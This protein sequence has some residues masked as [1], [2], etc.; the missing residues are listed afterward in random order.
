MQV[1]SF[2]CQQIHPIGRRPSKCTFPLL[3]TAA[4]LSKSTNHG[5]LLHCLAVKIGFM[6]HAPI[7]NSLMHMYASFDAFNYAVHVFDEMPNRDIVSYN[8]FLGEYVKGGDL[9]K[10]ES[11]FSSMPVI[12]VISWS[13]L[14]K[15]YVRN[16]QFEKGLGLCYQMLIL[17]L[18]PDEYVIVTLLSVITHFKLVPHGKM[19]HGFVIKRWLKITERVRTA[20]INFYCKCGHANSAIF[21]FRQTMTKNVSLWNTLISGIA[22]L[23]LEKEALQ[24]FTRMQMNGVRPN[25]DTFVCLLLT[26]GH[27]GLVEEGLEYFDIMSS[28]YGMKPTL[29]HYW[30]LVNLFVRAGQSDEALKIVQ[31]LPWDNQSSIWDA[32]IHLSK[33]SN[34]ISIGEYLGRKM[35]ELEPDNPMRYMPLL[36]LYATASRRDKYWEVMN[37]MKQRHLNQLSDYCHSQGV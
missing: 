6:L 22:S 10:A 5:K 23:G 8:T 24:L 17:G 26:C 11:L 25:E 9:E 3:I 13:I 1:L 28:V 7:P 19:V 2:F 35:I 27:E 21:L 37:E 31:K 34:D 29:A 33:E 18:I 16:R 30:C 12:N 36:N 4:K 20:L 14:I 32:L 15:G